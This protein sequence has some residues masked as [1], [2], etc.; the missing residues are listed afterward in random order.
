MYYDMVFQ[1]CLQICHALFTVFL[2]FVF[3]NFNR[4]FNR[5]LRLQKLT[6]FYQ[7]NK[8]FRI[9]VAFFTFFYFTHATNIIIKGVFSVIHLVKLLK[10][11]TTIMEIALFS[12]S[13]IIINLVEE[14]GNFLTMVFIA[15]FFF[16]MS[17]SIKKVKT[18]ILEHKR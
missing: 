2:V 13:S 6:Q 16:M 9:T 3:F 8:I 5:A 4:R 11:E 1:F 18:F 17:K 12:R 7:N 14:L 10:H 15:T